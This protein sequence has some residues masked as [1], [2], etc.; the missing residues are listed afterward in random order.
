[1][2]LLVECENLNGYYSLEKT[3]FNSIKLLVESFKNGSI[4][5]LPLAKLPEAV[6]R[7]IFM[8]YNTDKFHSVI[9]EEFAFDGI[10]HLFKDSQFLLLYGSKMGHIY[11]TPDVEYKL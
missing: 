4:L 2:K 7:E 9:H 10:V 11:H 6:E 3:G 5:K 8:N 1:M